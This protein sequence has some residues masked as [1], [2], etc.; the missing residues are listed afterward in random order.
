MTLVLK[1]DFLDTYFYFMWQ[2]LQIKHLFL[3]WIQLNYSLLI[4]C[5]KQCFFSP[6]VNKRLNLVTIDIYLAPQEYKFPINIFRSNGSPL[7]HISEKYLGLTSLKPAVMSNK[8]LLLSAIKP[9]CVKKKKKKLDLQ[10][11]FLKVL[12]NMCLFLFSSQWYLKRGW[13]KAINTL[14]L[15]A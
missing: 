12:W 14:F 6:V 4:W 3:H 2:N 11:K 15:I 9:C 13:R 5:H 7:K 8:F 1:S 10:I